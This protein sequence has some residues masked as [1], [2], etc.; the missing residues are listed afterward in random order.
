MDV[1]E[2]WQ[3]G[4]TRWPRLD[5]TLASYAAALA[6][7]WP[8]ELHAEDLYLAVACTEAAPGA[9]ETFEREHREAVVGFFGT[10]VGG[11]DPRELAQ[12]LF[13]ELMV[14]PAAKLRGYSGRGS[15]RAWLRMVAARRTLNA[16]RREGRRA[17][18][19]A[20][21]M[22]DATA[23][24]RDPELV[25]LKER[26]APAFEAAFRDAIAALPGETRG[27]LKLHYAEG[28]G[29]TALGRMHGWSKAT[30]SRRVA[31]AREGRLAVACRLVRERLRLDDRELESLIRLV[32]SDLGASLGGLLRSPAP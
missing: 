2:A 1:R 25:Y 26:Y 22:R 27:L 19:E 3:R 20:R 4:R 29:L 28:L 11:P 24:A 10:G 6:E 15:L 23:Q 17:S 13:V 30:T 21:A 18:L 5:V 32:R 7:G 14:G 12:E 16:R 31:H 9:A 8:R